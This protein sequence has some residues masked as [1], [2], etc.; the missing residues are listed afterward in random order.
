MIP[1]K[2]IEARDPG[3]YTFSIRNTDTDCQDRLHLFALFSFMQEAAYFNAESGGLGASTLDPMGLCWMLI[4]ISVRMESLPH[5]G[6]TITLDTWSRGSKKLTFLRDYEFYDQNGSKIGCATSEWLIGTIGDHRPQRP[7]LVLPDWQQPPAARSVFDGPTPRPP[8][9]DS[10]SCSQPILTL[11]ADFS[12]IDRNQH[13]NNTR[14]VAWSLNAIHALA[15]TFDDPP[16]DI[17]VIGLDIHYINEV[18]LGEKIY[19]YCQA[20]DQMPPQRYLVEARRAEDSAVV[21]RAHILTSI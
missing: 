4:R 16:D 18:R 5:W 19:C 8:Q 2:T 3:P 14:Y 13:V 11:Y 17:R 9:L 15:R 21:F 1:E 6:D 20:D 7:E 10:A 12:D